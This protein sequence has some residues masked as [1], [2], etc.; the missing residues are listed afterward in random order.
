MSSLSDAR[1]RRLSIVVAMVFAMMLTLMARLYWVQE[2]DPN[3]PTQTADATHDGVVVVPAA[4][5]MIVDANGTPLVTNTAY[6]EVLVDRDLLLRTP[7]QGAPVIARLAK[8]LHRSATLL[9]KQITPCSPTVPAPCWTGEP[10]QPVPVLTKAGQDIVLAIEEHA[11]LFP[12][13][14]VQTVSLPT[15]PNGDLAAHVLGYTGQITEADKQADPKLSDADTIG[16]SGLEASYDQALRGVDGTQIMKLNPQGYTVAAGPAQPGTPGDT[17]VTSIDANLQKL[18][19]QSMAQQIADSRK[20]GKPATGAAVVI[21]DPNTGRILA[22]ASYPTYD[23]QQ[24]IGG[25]SEADYQKLLN[26][27]A[28][29][30]LLDRAIQ[31]AYAPGSTFKLITSSSLIAHHEISLDGAYPCPGSLAVDGRVKTNY[32]SES[33]GRPLSLADALGYSCDTFFYA[34]TADEYYRDQARIDRGLN[35]QEFLQHMA[36]SYGVGTAPG[37][38]L[39]AAEQASGSYA[40]RET[41][42]VRWQQNKTQYCKDAATGFPGNPQNAY[43]TELARENCTDGWRYRAGDNADM[44]IG[45]GE[46]TMSPLQLAV[47]YS[48]VVNGGTIYEPT[49]GRALLDQDGKVVKEITPV[50]RSHTPV[51]QRFRNYF[52]NSLS[53]SRGWAVS[54]AFAYIGSPY[55]N[56]IGGKTGTAEVE[57][58]LDT[59]WLATW[60]PTYRDANGAM[61]AKFVMVGMVEQAG[62]G[63]T[64]AGPMLKRIWDGIFGV[65]QKPVIPGK[66]PETSIPH[67][68]LTPKGGT[69]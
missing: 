11:E 13:V 58:K 16:K 50:V 61:K 3:K 7:Q 27:S 8:L 55:Q 67:V 57:G 39:P 29:T 44:S 15:Y 68:V 42:L 32:D 17:L 26:P 63:A 38:D 65:G 60:G 31:G 64:A 45:Q 10:Y 59:S 34:P 56:Q 37:V 6:E 14:S 54:G 18:A 41:R 43:L 28:G 24:F 51:S 1:G 40:D 5:G 36:A 52:V 21:M 25:I 46:T 49:F 30:P 23:P 48:S 2:G 35:A 33:F 47:A 12:G 53:F 4:R 62:T 69:R 20:A 66:A 19:E 22:S 9:T